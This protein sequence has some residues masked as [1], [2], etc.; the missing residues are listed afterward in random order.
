MNI[1]AYQVAIAAIIFFSGLAGRTGIFIAAGLCAL[2]TLVQ[3][4]GGLT[5]LQIIVIVVSTILSF[6]FYSRKNEDH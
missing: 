6:A 5:I 4:N 3:T 2:W 1:L